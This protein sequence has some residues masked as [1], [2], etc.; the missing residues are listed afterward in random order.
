M[1]LYTHEAT[2]VSQAIPPSPPLYLESPRLFPGLLRGF[3]VPQIRDSEL[4]SHDRRQNVLPARRGFAGTETI[5]HVHDVDE[6]SS[7]FAG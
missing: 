5:S 6:R 3:L 7:I 4:I 1:T 2:R